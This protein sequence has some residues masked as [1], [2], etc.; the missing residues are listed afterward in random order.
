MAEPNNTYIIIGIR[1]INL[2]RTFFLEFGDRYDAKLSFKKIDDYK[3]TLS[4]E[5]QDR[6]NAHL[7]GQMEMDMLRTHGDLRIFPAPNTDWIIEQCSFL[8]RTSSDK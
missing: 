8:T 5:R 2:E 6:I 1:G 7:W 3:K 4:Q